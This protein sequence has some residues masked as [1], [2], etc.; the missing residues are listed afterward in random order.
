M[1]LYPEAQIRSERRKSILAGHPWIF[2][3]ALSV[4]PKASDGSLVSVACGQEILG[5]GYYN[6]RTDIAVRMLSRRDEMVD[7][8]FF[9]R[10]FLR[11]KQDRENWLPPETN[12]YRLVFAEADGCPGLIV[13]H[14]AGILVAQFHTMGMSLLQTAVITALKEVFSPIAIVERSDVAV[15]RHEGI[16]DQPVRVL[17]G[18]VDGEIEILENGYRFLVD[19]MRGQKTGFFLDQR[20]NRMALQRWCAGRSVLN[21]FCYTGAFSVYAAAKARR[22][23]S[24]DSSAPA[25][26]MCRKHMTLNGITAPDGDFRTEDAFDAL[27]SLAAGEFDCIVIDPPSFAKNR[28]QVANAIKAYTTLNTKA[29][30]ALPDGGILASASCTSHID[31]LTFLKILH[32]SAVN[33][34]CGLKVLEIKDQP[35]DHPYNLAFPEGRYL[36]FVVM[37]KNLNG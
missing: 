5:T 3:G 16:P 7:K 28:A 32:Q 24:L 26:A 21:T 31:P 22:V 30:Q 20:E 37:Q 4:L 34:G 25:M 17:H 10:K 6:S 15:R 8:E 2:S 11:L 19:A 27:T 13:D 14:Y 1:P 36:K 9:I 12:A 18:A 33:A 35:F 29:L 23:V